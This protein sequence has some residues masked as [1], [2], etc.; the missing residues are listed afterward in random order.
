MSEAGYVSRGYEAGE[1]SVLMAA[2]E[3]AE[4]KVSN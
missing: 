4:Y 2:E 3:Q 1:E